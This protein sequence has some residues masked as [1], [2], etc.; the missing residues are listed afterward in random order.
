MHTNHKNKNDSKSHEKDPSGSDEDDE[1]R[2]GIEHDWNRHEQSKPL[3]TEQMIIV[4]LGDTENVKETKIRAGFSKVKAEKMVNLLNEYQDIF[5]WSYTD[6][7]ELETRIVEHS[8]L[9][10]PSVPPMK[11]KLR[12]MIRE[13]SK[14]IEKEVMTL[15][16]VEFI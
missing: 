13:F 6:M 15:L 7:L 4:N 3:T 12:R 2:K 1:G 9:I 8:L 14:K 16:K 11:R 5:A 10:D